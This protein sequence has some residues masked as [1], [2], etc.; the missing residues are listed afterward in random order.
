[1]QWIRYCEDIKMNLEGEIVK[2]ALII[3]A[4]ALLLVIIGITG[5]NINVI[6]G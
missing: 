4:I 3:G 6:G 5:I 1:M 2:Y